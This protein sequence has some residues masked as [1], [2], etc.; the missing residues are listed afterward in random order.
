[1]KPIGALRMAPPKRV[2]PRHEQVLG[3]VAFVLAVEA[4]HQPLDA[5]SSAG[6][7]S[8]CVPPWSW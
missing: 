4:A 7:G 8:S 6:Q 1:V 2:K 5:I 3:V